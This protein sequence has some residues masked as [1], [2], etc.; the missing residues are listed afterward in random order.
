MIIIKDSGNDNNYEINDQN[1]DNKNY[2]KNRV[3]VIDNS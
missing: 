2:L 1:K 3:Y